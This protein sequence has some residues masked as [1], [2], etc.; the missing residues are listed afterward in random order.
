M[1]CWIEMKSLQ[2]ERL[3][4]LLFA[5]LLSPAAVGA[6]WAVWWVLVVQH[7][8]Q[9]SALTHAYRKLT[10]PLEAQEGPYPSFR[11]NQSELL[12][13]IQSIATLQSS[14]SNTAHSSWL[15]WKSFQRRAVP[16]EGGSRGP[17]SSKAKP[18][19]SGGLVT[20]VAALL[21]VLDTCLGFSPSFHRGDTPWDPVTT[22]K[23][24]ASATG[25]QLPGKRLLPLPVHT[26][27]APRASR[28][29]HRLYKKWGYKDI[30][31]SFFWARSL[32]HRFFERKRLDA[33]KLIIKA[34]GGILV[35]REASVHSH[36]RWDK[37]M[38]RCYCSKTS[39]WLKISTAVQ[40][41]KALAW[42][43]I[44]VFLQ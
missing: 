34:K 41:C 6:R 20:K 27:P 4:I 26:A 38:L 33:L 21:P 40:F 17:E 16:C 1:E 28:Q 30:I 15:G 9:S 39:D 43:A 31:F 19:C 24:S 13:V 8:E 35:M 32:Y 18:E 5:W 11:N 10:A 37:V 2:C 42:E 7:R 14:R 22:C 12:K 29:C 44:L 23:A 3:V 25:Q 36:P